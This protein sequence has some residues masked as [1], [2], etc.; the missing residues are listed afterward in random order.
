MHY[1]H[2]APVDTVFSAV[3]KFFSLCILTD[4]PTPYSQLTKIASI[5]FN[6]THFFMDPLKNEKKINHCKKSILS[7]KYMFKNIQ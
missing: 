7:S 6:K 5:I 1:D 2:Y 3:D 4:Q